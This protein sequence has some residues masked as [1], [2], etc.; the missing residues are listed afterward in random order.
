MYVNSVELLFWSDHSKLSQW[1]KADGEKEIPVSE[2]ERRKL[3]TTGQSY[4]EAL[5]NLLPQLAK[6][7]IILEDGLGAQ[8]IEVA[9][10]KDHEESEQ[11][12]S[13]QVF[14]AVLANTVH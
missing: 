3:V 14:L 10:E 9:I 8:M 6:N 4:Q 5:E 13:E 1:M 12:P 2:P 7:D 11:S